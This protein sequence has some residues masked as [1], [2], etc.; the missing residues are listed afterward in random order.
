M[1]PEAEVIEILKR[2]ANKLTPP[3]LNAVIGKMIVNKTYATIV[4]ESTE[5]ESLAE[6][7]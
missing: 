2:E 5:A 1:K 7:H 6:V 3:T 4:L